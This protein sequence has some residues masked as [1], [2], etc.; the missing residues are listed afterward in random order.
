MLI[1]RM[2]LSANPNNQNN[3]KVLVMQLRIL[4]KWS[5]FTFGIA[6]MAFSSATILFLAKNK[7]VE[8]IKSI[9]LLEQINS[10]LPVRLTIPKINVD[11]AFEYVGITAGGAM[12]VP[13]SPAEVAWFKLG[14]RPGEKGSAVIAGHFGWKNGI[15]AAFD[16]L[17][18]LQKGDRV[19]IEDEKGVKTSFVVRESRSYDAKAD[20]S[21]VFDSGDGKAH[22]NLIT[23][24]GVW[25]KTKKSYSDRLIV[26]TDKEIK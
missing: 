24:E 8:T 21:D 16:D 15:A 5:L 23:C 10:G 1:P 19:Y 4:L 25:N 14:I 26:F 18:K 11:T 22:L 3:T 6:G 12:D 17:N 7:S 20:A 9:V 2:K 13:K